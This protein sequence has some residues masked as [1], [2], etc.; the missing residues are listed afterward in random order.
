[1][2][3]SK[4]SSRFIKNHS[5]RMNNPS[6]KEVVKSRILPPLYTPLSKSDR[7]ILI[8]FCRL[9]GRDTF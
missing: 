9:L 1:M 5:K 3:T 6:K 4:D 8:S 2:K 7:L